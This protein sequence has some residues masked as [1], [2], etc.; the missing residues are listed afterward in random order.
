MTFLIC[1]FDTFS[2]RLRA[3]Y[4]AFLGGVDASGKDG[5]RPARC[6]PRKWRGG[7]NEDGATPELDELILYAALTAMCAREVL[8]EDRAS[9]VVGVRPT[10]CVRSG[11]TGHQRAPNQ[12]YAKE[13]ADGAPPGM[14]HRAVRTS[15]AATSKSDAPNAP[16]NRG[17]RTKPRLRRSRPRGIRT[18]DFAIRGPAFCPFGCDLARR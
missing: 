16:N 4:T 9:E 7:R 17:S 14:R 11:C 10:L 18:R 6:L 8:C 13:M 3:C 5:G 1:H 15:T 2:F 12:R